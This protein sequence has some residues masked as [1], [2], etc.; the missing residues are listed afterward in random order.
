METVRRG[1]TTECHLNCFADRIGRTGLEPVP[2]RTL[3]LPATTIGR[4]LDHPVLG[5]FYPALA[6]ARQAMLVTA[7]RRLHARV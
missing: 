7:D 4:R 3:A 6:E 2:V 1:E 5:C